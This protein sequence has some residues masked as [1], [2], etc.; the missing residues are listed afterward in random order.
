MYLNFCAI[1]LVNSQ[2]LDQSIALSRRLR[3]YQQG[4]FVP[5]PHLPNGVLTANSNTGG[6]RQPVFANQFSI[7][8]DIGAKGDI[9]LGKSNIGRARK[10]KNHFLLK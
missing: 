2:L 6:S 10:L 5:P 3:V 9:L 4:Y 1:G 8:I 7:V